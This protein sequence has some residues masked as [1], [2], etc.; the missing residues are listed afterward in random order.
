M[1]QDLTDYECQILATL[2][3]RGGTATGDV[4]QKV[5]PL[6]GSNMHQH[7]GAVRSWLLQLERK[8]FVRKLDDQRPVCW[9]K[10]AAAVA[11]EP[12]ETQEQ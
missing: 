10:T 4:A 6:F 12:P 7:S 2:D 8:G 11:E 1:T 5:R 3:T 9:V